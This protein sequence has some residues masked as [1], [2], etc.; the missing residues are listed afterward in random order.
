ML[1][2]DKFDVQLFRLDSC[3]RNKFKKNNIHV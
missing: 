1:N 3:S 2:N